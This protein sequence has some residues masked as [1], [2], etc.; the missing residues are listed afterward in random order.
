MTTI[1]LT[2]VTDWV[3]LGER[4]RELETR[5]NCSFFQSWTWT[6]C[7]AE[8]RFSDPV[9]L[10]ATQNGRRVAMG[11][12]NRRR[13]WTGREVLFLG[14]S[15]SPDCDAVFIEW[16]GLLAETG[17]PA[18][19]LADCLTAAR[20]AP[21]AGRRP[22]RRRSL[23]LSGIDATGLEVAQRLGRGL[24]VPR[25]MG[26]PFVDLASLRQSGRAYLATL[27]AN[28]RYQIR[29]SN[30]LYGAL[31]LQRAG[32][33]DEALGFLDQ[34]ASLHQATWRSRG[35][36][37][38]FADPYFARFHRALIQRGFGRGEIAMLRINSRDRIVG[39]LYNFEWRGNVLAYQSGFDY[40]GA[41]PHQKP[42]LTCHHQAIED[43]ATRGL[44]HYDFLAGADRYKRSLGTSEVALHW[45]ELGGLNWPRRLGG[46]LK[47]WARPAP[48]S[49]TS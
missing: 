20:T 13:N 43:A 44:D 48:G 14:E 32:S 30:R 25:S 3:A 19:L 36:P 24:F 8:E 34:L 11:L 49:P 12:F 39:F 26:A 35:R 42:G 16:N 21:I 1:T 41:R 27:S 7:L 22:R 18:A 45:A 17:T 31:T 47:D 5:S 10:E 6:G 40:P 15:G 28:S 29:R 23:V 46:W 9:L 2:P 38:A 37:G 33:P 4:W